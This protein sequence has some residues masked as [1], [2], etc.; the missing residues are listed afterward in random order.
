MEKQERQLRELESEFRSLLI[1]ALK[2]CKDGGRGVFLTTEEAR[3]Q[4]NPVL[5][6]R[7]VWPETK[8]LEEL[9]ERIAEL[10]GSLGLPVEES[11]YG[12]FLKYCHITGPNAPGAW[13]LALECL[14]ELEASSQQLGA[15]YA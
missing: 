7:L 2:K 1:P 4:T 3:N 13:K 10:R 15:I 12:L 8:R 14:K 5:Y 6:S 9:G 11:A